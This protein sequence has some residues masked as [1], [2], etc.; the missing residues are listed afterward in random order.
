MITNTNQ[1]N[2][3][4]LEQFRQYLLSQNINPGTV[5]NYVSD[6]NHFLG[7]LEGIG[8]ELDHISSDHIHSYR[9][10]LLE[11]LSAPITTVNRRLTSL[12][13]F[14]DW[15]ASAQIWP[16]N[17]AATLSNVSFSE[18]PLVQTEPS[19]NLHPKFKPI[20]I[21]LAG[22]L[23][24]LLILGATGALAF[25]LK[26]AVGEA[27]GNVTGIT[28][29]TLKQVIDPITNKIPLSLLPTGH[30][31]GLDA[32]RVDGFH[33]DS[34]AKAIDL[35]Q[36]ISNLTRKISEIETS[37]GSLA[38]AA[39]LNAAKTFTAL[40]T[41]T[42]GLTVSGGILTLP[43][44]SV[45]SG[46]IADG[47]LLNADVASNAA[48]NYS[49][50]NLS[51]SILG[52]DL[53]PNIVL[54]TTGNLTTTGSGLITSA[55]LLTASNGFVLNSG[56]LT[57]PSASVSDTSLSSNVALLAGIQ[58]FTGSKTFSTAITAPSSSNTING[59]V[60][61]SGN[62]TL[63]NLTTSTGSLT[64]TVADGASAVAFTLAT[65]TTYSTSGA[66][67]LSLKNGTTE[68][69]SLNKDGLLTVN[70]NIV[71][72]GTLQ[73]TQLIST[74]STGTP[75][76]IVSST[77]QVANLNASLLEG[78]SSSTLM[79]YPQPNH[80]TNSDFSRRNRWMTFMPE[81]FTD[82]SG[83]TLDAGSSIGTVST[84]TGCTGN[85][86]LTAGNTGAWQ[87]KAGLNTWKDVRV[88]AQFK[89]TDTASGR[90]YGVRRWIDSNNYI[91]AYLDTTPT[92]RLNLRVVN[93][94]SP[95]NQS[96]SGAPTITLN[97]WYWIELETQG[98]GMA[99]A[100]IYTTSSVN[101]VAKSSAILADTVTNTAT[102][103]DTPGQV[104]LFQIGVTTAS[105]WGGLSTGDGGVYVEGWGPESWDVTFAGIKGGQAFGFN[106]A[107][108]SGPVGKQWAARVFLPKEDRDVRFSNLSPDGSV[109]PS[110]TYIGSMYA[111]HV[112][113]GSGTAGYRFFLSLANSA[114]T[115]LF[116]NKIIDVAA[117][118]STSFTR[119]TIVNTPMS[120]ASARRTTIGSNVV[121]GSS[122]TNWIF[123][124]LLPQIEQ[125]SVATPWRNALEDSA[126][127]VW[128]LP[129][130]TPFTNDNS[131]TSGSA[132]INPRDLSGNL[133]LPWDATVKI[134]SAVSVNGSNATSRWNMFHNV[135][136][137]P[138]VLPKKGHDYRKGGTFWAAGSNQYAPTEIEIIT[139]LAAGKRRISLHWSII[140]T[141]L[142]ISSVWSGGVGY[143]M[144]TATRGKI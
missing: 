76:L 75:P 7:W 98:V 142:T 117:S 86:V 108:D 31:N 96:G 77:T 21:A 45:T 50:L 143:T 66:K 67:V 123:E 58:T 132:E 137:A 114:G 118:D 80:I 127:L 87:I 110:T 59:L 47:T 128:F 39:L 94:G 135:D 124:F 141:P 82:T 130:E 26:Q 122:F 112:S 140:D 85:C 53:A 99:I 15:A 57:L 105:Q 8:L 33:A 60:V 64:S 3:P 36:N 44:N 11:E 83:W 139:S 56:T 61:S 6:I 134:E 62:V 129:I 10:H 104:T 138:P 40:Q 93:A 63:A 18:T 144:V 38:D 55:G 131:I 30:G 119:R 113:V 4:L 78:N 51:T 14:G 102:Q 109:V 95:S 65:S 17:H 72:T 69:L 79:S 100:K 120:S 24:T 126:P 12:R 27:L 97:N 71:A 28:E 43:T 23:S 19:L 121:A 41:F 70:G 52:G 88:S 32:D 92:A 133:F 73:G 20:L 48:I 34:F 46:F 16:Q 116:G 49:K 29:V 25:N 91:E 101:P 90:Q 89:L 5:G 111:R 115:D 106:E 125:G 13:R 103:P 54:T 37:L 81:T 107:A 22:S 74:V 84:A 1:P 9:R 35:D 42:N 68:L 136:G 2:T